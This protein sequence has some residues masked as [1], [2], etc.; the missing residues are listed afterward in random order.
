MQSRWKL[1]LLLALVALLPRVA[2]L[3]QY[4]ESPYYGTVFLDELYHY[5]WASAVARGRILGD[6]AF[7][8]APLY[9]Y[10]L[11]ALFAITGPNLLWPRVAQIAL[12][13]LATALVFLLG[14]RLFGRR[15]GILAWAFA[16]FYGPSVFFEAELLDVV[17]QLAFFPAIALAAL[18]LMERPRWGAAAA[19]GLLTGLCALARPN[20]LL[21]APFLI[22]ISLWP[23]LPGT[24]PV[25]IRRLAA[26]AGVY[27]AVMALAILPATIHNAIAGRAFVPIAS[28]GGIN[29]YLGNNE[30]ADGHTP[31]TR[32]HYFAF[33]RYRDSVELFAEKEAEAALGRPLSA[34]EVS[35]YWSARAM[36][37]IVHSPGAFLRLLARKF[38]FFWNDLEIKNNK[39]LA[40]VGQQIPVLRWLML[41]GRWGVLA[42]I[43]LAGMGMALRRRASVTQAFRP[44]DLGPAAAP[45]DHRL[46]SLRHEN[47]DPTQ[48]LSVQVRRQGVF[49]L[50]GFLLVF[51]VSVILFF[52]SDRHRLPAVPLLAVFAGYAVDQAIERF[53]MRRWAA[54]FREA[55]LVIILMALILPHWFQSIAAEWP[56]RDWWTLGNCYKDKGDLE[57]A[58]AAY[59]RALEFGPND[60]DLWNN[61][62]ETLFRERR[63]VEAE[64]AFRRAF[65]ADSS[66]VRALNNLA[67]SLQERGALGE[68]EAAFRR[69]LEIAPDYTL[70]RKNLADLLLD[71]N[72]PEEALALY[73][74]TLH[75][76]PTNA[77]AHLG[78]ARALFALGRVDEARQALQSAIDLGGEKTVDRA[79]ELGLGALVNGE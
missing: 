49:L 35:G 29:F 64:K 5:D 13:A 52:V 18:R 17:L 75:E 67:V 70:A 60:P 57:H 79:R 42:P 20:I 16:A 71:V 45:E 33:D 10:L 40:F 9:S 46:E 30:T 25:Q 28:F 56:A 26:L 43:G 65:E 66:Y 74:Q 7:F 54:L 6:Q 37:V 12:G 44:V 55:A 78:R 19:L 48:T 14:E 68:A 39:D 32:R 59:R 27:A 36:G 76:W 15:A 21:F 69:A 8:R 3:R 77:E 1:A 22:A 72:Q 53:R 63:T 58:E 34:A 31:R 47:A 38:A 41:L 73:N 11:G 2:Y 62:G 51:M 24:G 50:A 4:I 23:A 61:L